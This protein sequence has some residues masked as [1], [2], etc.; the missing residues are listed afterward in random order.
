MN[1]AIK[2]FVASK[3]IA[4]VGVS[5]GG[6]KFGNTIFTEL[7]QRGYSVYIVHPEAKE[8]NGEPC[9]PNLQALQGKVDAVLVSVPPANAGQVIEDAAAAGIHN[10]WLQQGSESPEVLQRASELGLHVVSGK[11]VLMYAEPVTSFHT[12]HRFFAKL[13]GAY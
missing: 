4:V 13:F 7:K 11:C 8:I 6:A 1:Q 5:R 9:Y 12:V 10:V 3:A 2:D